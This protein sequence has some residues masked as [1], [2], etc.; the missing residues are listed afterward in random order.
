VVGL[1]EVGA[2]AQL[3]AIPMGRLAAI[4]AGVTDAQAATLPTAGMTAVRA[5][6]SFV[7]R[8]KKGELPLRVRPALWVDARPL[9]GLL[10]CDYQ[11]AGLRPRPSAHRRPLVS[12]RHL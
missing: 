3:A 8:L 9:P 11:G 6:D 12:L 10:S 2:C 5:L 1:V 7:L 4:R